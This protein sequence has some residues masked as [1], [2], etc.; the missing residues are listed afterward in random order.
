MKDMGISAERLDLSGRN[1]L[2]LAVSGLSATSQQLALLE[3]CLLVCRLTQE[4]SLY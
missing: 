3:G 1:M 2:D 4:H